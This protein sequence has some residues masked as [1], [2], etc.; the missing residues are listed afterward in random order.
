MGLIAL[1][2]APMRKRSTDEWVGWTP[3]R[4]RFEAEHK[5]QQSDASMQLRGLYE[6]CVEI[7]KAAVAAICPDGLATAKEL[8]KPN[9]QVARRL[10]A[11]GD[12]SEEL[13]AKALRD[14]ERQNKQN[15]ARRDQIG[16]AH[17]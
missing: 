10:L 2:N 3:A 15:V 6:N 16:R 8:A 4:L 13:R 5:R 17:V 12:R 9:A 14:L 7:L 1:N 11:A